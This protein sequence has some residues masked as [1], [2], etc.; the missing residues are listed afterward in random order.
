MET[1]DFEYNMVPLFGRKTGKIDISM[2]AAQ[3]LALV[4]TSRYYCDVTWS[5]HNVCAKFHK[6]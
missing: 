1:H 5:Y 3:E 4:P 6:D 2:S